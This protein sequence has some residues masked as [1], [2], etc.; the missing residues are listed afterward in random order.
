MKKGI[1][2]I[3]AA[4]VLILLLLA[5]SWLKAVFLPPPVL[6]PEKAELSVLQN[7]HPGEEVQYSATVTL[8]LGQWIEKSKLHADKA[9]VY[10]VEVKFKSFRFDRIKWEMRGKFRV[11]ETGDFPGGEL[12]F[13]AVSIP[14]SRS[15]EYGI[16]IPAQKSRLPENITPGSELLL[17]PE[18]GIEDK[19]A[20]RIPP[21][22]WWAAA[23]AAALLIAAAVIIMIYLIRRK[24][25]I[26]AIALDE[27]TLKEIDFI[28]R[29]VRSGDIPAAKGFAGVCDILRNYLEER[30]TL[31]VTRQT[32]LE[33]IRSL[34]LPDHL[35]PP[36][37]RMFL[38]EFLNTCDRIKFAGAEAAENMLDKA[39]AEAGELVRATT[40]EKEEEKK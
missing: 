40:P 14:G 28:C 16:K 26:P 39:A 30:F 31:P 33:F 38:T 23:A 17:A 18:A 36:E 8:P 35:L 32:T 20:N 19:P 37:N 1:F 34:T 13:S 27:K 24:K 15:R 25:T 11:L 21:R 9:V 10:P 3:L 29:R 22:L 4:I 5:G 2:I 6:I 7:I 12:R